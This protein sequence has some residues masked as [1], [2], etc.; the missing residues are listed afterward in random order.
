MLVNMKEIDY[1]KRLGLGFDDY[2]KEVA[3]INRMKLFFQKPNSVQFY[4]ED[5]RRLCYALGV[6]CYLDDNQYH[7][8]IDR[9]KGISR[10]WEYLKIYEDEFYDFLVSLVLFVNTYDGYKKDKKT[11]LTVIK[12]ALK[13]SY[14]DFEVTEDKDGCYFFP[15]GAKELDKA[16]VSQP[17]DWLID[18]PK[19]QKAFSKALKQYSNKKYTRDI[20]D[21]FRK[22]LEEFFKEFL[23]NDKNL[24]N[25]TQEIFI[26]L[27]ENNAE[28]ELAGMIKSLLNSYDKLN[29]SAVKHNDKLDK[30]Y[31][32]F[33][34]YQTGIFIR[35]LIVVRQQEKW[36]ET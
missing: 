25:N 2:D 17:L 33:I 32:E 18:Y 10:V 11:M 4:P 35:T 16:L 3:F 23:N 5:E 12:R 1:R 22:A 21:N 26:Y 15:K 30:T 31:L 6:S 28:P 9:I 14:I 27:K 20:A 7:P 24:H 36:Y 13:D 29:N 8:N 34:M 19:T